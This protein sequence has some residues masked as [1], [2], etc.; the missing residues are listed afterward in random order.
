LKLLIHCALVL[1][2]FFCTGLVEAQVTEKEVSAIAASEKWLQWVDAG[3]YDQSWHGAAAVFKN[4]V[5]KEQWNQAIK[6]ARHT[7]GKLVSRHI[8]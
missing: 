3:D 4:A 1:C 5:P 8:T 2:L 6:T 7:F